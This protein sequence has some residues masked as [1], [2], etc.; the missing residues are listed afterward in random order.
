MLFEHGAFTASDTDATARALVWLALG[1]PAQVLFKALAPA[2]F[3]RENTAT[4]LMKFQLPGLPS[5]RSEMP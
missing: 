5:V 3:A 4:P 2:F 1:L